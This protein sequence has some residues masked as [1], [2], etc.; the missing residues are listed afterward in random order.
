M[1]IAT[2]EGRCNLLVLCK[3]YI[4]FLQYHTIIES[5]ITIAYLAWLI[6]RL[7][8]QEFSILLKIHGIEIHGLEYS[9]DK[10]S[11][12]RNSRDDSGKIQKHGV[13]SV[14]PFWHIWAPKNKGPLAIVY[15]S[16][17]LW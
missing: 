4:F 15:V 2:Y 12:S 1:K 9:R 14:K 17:C 6:H 5:Y 7:N 13:E 8:I 10:N 11:R 3:V 16:H